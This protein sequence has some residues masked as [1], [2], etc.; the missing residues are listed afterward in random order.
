M[1]PNIASQDD[2][3]FEPTARW[4]SLALTL[5]AFLMLIVVVVLMG[6]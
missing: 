6:Q 2:R 4:L 5:L 1:F 3:N